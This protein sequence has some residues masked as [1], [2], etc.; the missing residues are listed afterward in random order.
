VPYIKKEDRKKFFGKQSWAAF[1]ELC[2]SPGDLNYLL[3]S[4]LTRYVQD[5]GESYATYNEV[6]GVLECAKQE[7]YRRQIAPYE[8]KKCD[9]NGD[10]YLGGS[11]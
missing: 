4:I 10:V 11:R 2:E 8:D 7:L 9:D 5:K 1:V 6:I 3:T